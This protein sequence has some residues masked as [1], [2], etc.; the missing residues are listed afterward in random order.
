MYLCTTSACGERAGDIQANS[1]HLGQLGE[2]LLV[3]NVGGRDAAVERHASRVALSWTTGLL[4]SRR[5]SSLGVTPKRTRLGNVLRT[6]NDTKPST[7]I[8]ER[9]NSSV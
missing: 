2:W 6:C 5:A 3:Y 9:K 8:C 7:S 1:A 4:V